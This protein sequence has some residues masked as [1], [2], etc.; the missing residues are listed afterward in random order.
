MLLGF[1]S[2]LLSLFNAQIVY[3]ENRLLISQ[4]FVGMK[5]HGVENALIFS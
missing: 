4:F 5:N 3:I 2:G 1:Y